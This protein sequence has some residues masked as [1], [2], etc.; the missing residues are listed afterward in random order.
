MKVELNAEQLM[1]QEQFKD[2]VDSEIIPYA[3]LNDSEER[4]HPELLA[5]ITEAGY[6]GSMLPKEYGGMELDNITIGI[7]NEEVGRGC[8]SVRSL[9]T[10]QGMVGLA[11]LRWGTEQQRQYWL[12][13]L[14]T[15]TTLGSFGLTE[16]S[17]G[18]DAKSI[19][20]TAV[21]DGD[22]YILNGHKKWITMGQ[23]A[24]VFLILAQCENKPTA[25]I[26]ERDSIGFSVEPMSGLLGARASMI[27]EL[28]MDSCRIPKENLLGQVGT[29]LS[30]VALPCLDYGRYTIACGCVGLAKACLDA[31]V[32]YANSRIQFGRAIRENQMIQK[33]ITEMSV[34]MKAARMLCYRAGYLRDVGDPE[35]IMETWTAKYFASTM[36]NKVAS[37]AVQIH[38]ANGCHR[39]YPV[40]RYYRDARINEI[41]EGTTQMHEILIATQEV[42][43]HRREMRRSNKAEKVKDS[44]NRN[45]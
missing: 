9:L 7:L 13:A 39:D 8:S 10:V 5:K 30:H 43:T 27:A 33:M 42:V 28:K 45:V 37:D 2:F 16:P 15:G 29:G 26:V 41:I 44:A 25:F 22:E 3:S 38:G 40:E 4:I 20:T 31:S 17:V 18:S 35:S 12:P 1:W 24:D 6:L 19:E 14:A 32:H 34:N 11:I 21:L 23:L 36:V